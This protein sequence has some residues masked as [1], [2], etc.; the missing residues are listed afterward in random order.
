MAVPSPN[1]VTQLLLDWSNGYKAAVDRLMPL[2]YHELRR[3]AHHYMGR[4]RPG[5]SLQTTALVN[6][7]YLQPHR[8]EKRAVAKSGSFFR[9]S[10]TAQAAY[11]RRSRSFSPLCETWRSSPSGAA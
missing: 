2:V 5:H 11:P 4:E 1:E 10:I 7:A 8:P 6:E 3:L 9:H